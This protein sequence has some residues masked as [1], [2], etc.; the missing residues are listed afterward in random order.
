MT[1]LAALVERLNQLEANYAKATT[2]R[3]HYR[4]LYLDMLERCK[5]LER[6]LLG[7]KAE[8]LPA[9]DSQLTLQLLG[10]LLEASAENSAAADSNE[11]SATTPD[12]TS[13]ASTE[14]VRGHT[15]RKP[16]GRGPL[17]ENLPR[18][19]IDLIPEEVQREGLDAFE[20]L[21]GEVSVVLERRRASLVALHIHRPKFLRKDRERNAATKFHVADPVDLPI[22]R[23]LAGPGL[24]ADTAVKR[25]QDHLPLHRLEKIY[26]REGVHLARSTLCS[27]H[28]ELADLVEPLVAAMWRDAKAAPYLCTDATGVLVQAKDQCRRGHFW[29]VVVPARHVL[30]GYSARHDSAAVDK[31]FA[32]YQG[33]LVADAH[34]VY[35]H[36]YEDGTILEVGCWAHARRYFF[37]ALSSDPERAREALAFITTLFQ[38]ERELAGQSPKQ[39][40]AAR[41]ARG[42][43]VVD[44]FFEWCARWAEH[45]LDDT[46]IAKG[47]GYV[48]N[49]REALQRFL[50]DG[51]LPLHNNI[52]ELHLRRQA[53]G[54]KNW[55]F[56]GNDEGGEVNATMVS[57]LASC[58]MHGIEPLGYLRDLICLLPYWRHHRVL[59]LAPVN[60]RETLEQQEAR[61]I[62]AENVCRRVATGE[63]DHL[64][65]G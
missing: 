58:E 14:Q 16:K 29:V 60:W 43:P 35:D 26:E 34:A 42:K 31:L 38:L 39:R 61:E 17:P 56:V 22:E 37:K 41:Q 65:K 23:G 48:R 2:E 53:V 20:Q 5:R 45:V 57:L 59:E 49:Q 27:W 21:P 18:I 44:A 64:V 1:E 19:D 33:Y 36:L 13:E 50:I 63:L 9:S 25:F 7:Q 28:Q 30:Y 52:S 54:R 10:S 11:T 6:G 15:R 40:K 12:A 47:L 55:L 24:L 8:R 62:L 46:P 3:E 4:R 32:G 51:R